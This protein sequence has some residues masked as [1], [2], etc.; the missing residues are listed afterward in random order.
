MPFISSTAV[1]PI[2]FVVQ[3][4]G[5]QT[6]TARAS[7]V[8][9]TPKP[10]PSFRPSPT[11]TTADFAPKVREATEA[12]NGHEISTVKM[13]ATAVRPL[14]EEVGTEHAETY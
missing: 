10:V 6:V 3:G 7:G 11:A 12:A 5:L 13:P 8:S 14:R 1:A 4:E 9:E 2:P